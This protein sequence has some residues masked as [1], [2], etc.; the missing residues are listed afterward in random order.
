M[1][2]TQRIQTY[3]IL[4]FQADDELVRRAADGSHG[5]GSYYNIYNANELANALTKVLANIVLEA[6]TAFV[7]PVVPSSPENRTE[8]GQRVYL[9]F[10]KPITQK[11]WYGN[12]KKYGIG[13]DNSI[14]DVNGIATTNSDGTF[15][16]RC[17]ILLEFGRRRGGG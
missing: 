7:A 2:G 11:P 1:D 14:V 9:G 17:S 10:F 3:T 13:S 16:V 8:S 15:N 6:N 4:A 5:R 12:L